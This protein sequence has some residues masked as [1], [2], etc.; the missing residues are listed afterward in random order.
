MFSAFKMLEENPNRREGKKVNHS[1]GIQ[2]GINRSERPV[3][4]DTEPTCDICP[5]VLYFCSFFCFHRSTN[6]K[7]RI[8]NSI[9]VSAMEGTSIVKVRNHRF[10]CRVFWTDMLIIIIIMIWTLIMH[11]YPS[12]KMLMANSK[13]NRKRKV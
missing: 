6:P 1:F 12:H 8:C 13:F 10:T 5:Q 4:K 11:R 3:E 7:C 2:T 9:C